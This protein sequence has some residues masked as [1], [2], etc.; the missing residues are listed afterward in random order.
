MCD[1]S[2]CHGD[3]MPVASVVHSFP[4]NHWHLDPDRHYPTNL[5]PANYILQKEHS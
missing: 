4:A 2:A 1:A 3:A 5:V